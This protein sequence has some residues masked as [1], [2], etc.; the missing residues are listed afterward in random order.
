VRNL[1]SHKGG[2]QSSGKIVDRNGNNRND[3]LLIVQNIGEAQTG[4]EQIE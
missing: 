1:D 3:Q 4:N 2:N